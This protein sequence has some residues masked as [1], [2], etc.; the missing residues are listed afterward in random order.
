MSLSIY[1]LL[2]TWRYSHH[3]INIPTAAVAH[4]NALRYVSRASIQ[5]YHFSHLPSYC[6]YCLDLPHFRA[7]TYCQ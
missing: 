3:H 1:C 2:H 7:A 5:Q 6:N 4:S